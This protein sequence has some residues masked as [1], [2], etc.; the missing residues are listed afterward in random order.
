MKL[1]Y[2]LYLPD[3]QILAI[4]KIEDYIEGTQVIQG[5]VATILKSIAG[6]VFKQCFEH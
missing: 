6:Q 2:P 5:H 3:L 1:D 4:S